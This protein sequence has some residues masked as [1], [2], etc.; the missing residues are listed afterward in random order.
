MLKLF[1]SLGKRLEPFKPENPKRVTL[2]TCGPSVY[3]SAHI[4]NFRTFLFEDIVVRYLEYTGHRVKRGMN[5]TDVED[6]AIQEAVAR[7]ISLK[8]LTDK[9]IEAFVR[10]MKRLRM[11]IPDYLL[12]A[13]EAVDESV[14]IIEQLLRLNIA[15]WY[16]G[17]VYF[18]PLKFPGFGK[19][20]GLDMSK[21]PVK[22]RR[23]HK[24]TYPGLNWNL[25]DFIL[26]HGCKK[27]DT[28]CWDTRIGRGRPSWNIQDPSMISKHFHETLSIYCGGYDNLF[29]HHD[30]SI[31]ILES[32]R[33]YPMAR[34]WLHCHHLVVNGQKMSKSKGN[35]VYPDTLR[36]QGY[37]RDQIR[38]FLI[39]GHYRKKLNYSDQAIRLAADKLKTFKEKIKALEKRARQNAM[40]KNDGNAARKVKELFTNRMDDDVDV[41]GAF[42]A[43][44]DFLVTADIRG[45]SPS[46]ASGYLKGLREIDQV[47]QV[48]FLVN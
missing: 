4:G 11:K 46:V 7:K 12:R 9:N 36:S 1:N 40:A 48:L 6:K 38:F 21:W 14:E 35:I 5:F 2:F 31:A 20:Y 25:G 26:W 44:Y 29:R 45:F 15:D 43:L 17:N 24:D 23:F 47:L 16:R 27:E 37:D 19:L 32:I 39:Y 41:R 18:D 33:P 28:V 13:S 22:K 10:E 34:F 8:M 3:Q 30:Y 42:D